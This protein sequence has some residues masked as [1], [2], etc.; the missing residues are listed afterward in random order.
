MDKKEDKDKNSKRDIYKMSHHS[1]KSKS[2]DKYFSKY[3]S[4]SRR[5]NYNEGNEKNKK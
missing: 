5:R 2:K 3:N 1:S 4:H